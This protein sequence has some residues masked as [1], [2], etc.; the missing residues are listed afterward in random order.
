MRY[1]RITPEIAASLSEI[2]GENFVIYNDPERLEPYSHDEIPEKKYAA[3]PEAVVRPRTADE[4][5]RIMKLANEFRFPVTPR[6]AGS[7]LSGGAVPIH[8][9]IVLHCDRMNEILELDKENMMLTVEPGVVANDINE[10]LKPHGL[11]YAGYPMSM[12][13]CY[14][15]GNVA[16]NAGGG[17]AVKY[18]VTG[19][20]VL[21][22]ETVMPNGDIV[23]FGG[24]LIKDVTGYNMIQ[25]MTGS[26]GTLGIFSKIVL[27]L[28]PLPRYQVD[29]L[30]LFKS[31]QEAINIVPRIITGTG[32]I[33]T[34]IEFMDR[35]ACREACEYLNES[36][37]YQDSGA[38]VI[39]TVDGASRE[40]VESEYETLGEMCMENGAIEVYVADNVTTSERIWK[41]RRNIGE[42]YNVISRR[43]SGEDIVV[44]PAAMA[45][46]VEKLSQLAQNFGVMIPCFGHAGD[47]N[48]HAR[49][50]SDPKWSDEKWHQVLPEILERLYKLTSEL[51]GSI[52]GEH[53]IGH[54]RKNYM[55][56][57]VSDE[58]LNILKSIKKSLDPNFILNPGKIF[59]SL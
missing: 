7:G 45:Q 11:F 19:R 33:P 48:L 37:P 43:Q 55:P 31:S 1:N 16:E 56:M 54:K 27:K 59:D 17:K 24:K 14:I 13:T 32:I 46:M 49:I 40:N 25:L 44:P 9:G 4:I 52:S 39:I 42:A 23:W 36:I 22:L 35:T 6:G 30:C 3:M 51:G 53:G 10:F 28:I 12:E 2:V 34:G 26:E 29:L 57:F 21:G 38:M 8:G 47:G 58:Y 50:V 18:G 41:V 5:S 15:G 20:Y